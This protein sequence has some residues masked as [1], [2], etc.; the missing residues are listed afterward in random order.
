MR[1]DPR[2]CSIVERAAAILHTPMAAISIV[3]RDRQW[4]PASVGLNASETSRDFS[5]CAHAIEHPDETLCVP[6]ALADQ[7]FAENPLV[8]GEPHIRFYAGV[9]LVAEG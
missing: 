9:P 5:F 8:T 6:D 3:D 2:L 1:A 4:F 7:R